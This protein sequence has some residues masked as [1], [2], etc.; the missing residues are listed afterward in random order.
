[1]QIGFPGHKRIKL[2]QLR[3]IMKCQQFKWD[4]Y[5]WQLKSL[6]QP[7]QDWVGSKPHIASHIQCRYNKFVNR[8]YAHL[9]DPKIINITPDVVCTL[10]NK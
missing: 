8:G 4:A 1:M 5:F 6:N 2:L 7:I 9:Q 10:Q 3:I